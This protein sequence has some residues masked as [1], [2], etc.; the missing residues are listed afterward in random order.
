MLIIL[1]RD[2]VIN[3]DP[4]GYI[5]SPENW[6]AISG[7]IEAIAALAKAGHKVT[8]CSNQSGIGRGLITPEQLDRI[9]QKMTQ[10]IENAG[11]KLSGI[12]ICPHHPDDNC[13][14]RKPKPSL[15]QQIIAEHAVTGEDIWAI[16]DS[17]R[18]V[19]AGLATGCKTALVLTGNG[20]KQQKDLSRRTNTLIFPDLAS[21][22]NCILSNN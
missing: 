15:Y 3:H 8:V 17:V 4:V 16:G 14:C 5:N 6:H 21:A 9:H 12:Y 2:G 13:D 22:T 7:S 19:E 1:D 20:I 11:G 10:A 18:D